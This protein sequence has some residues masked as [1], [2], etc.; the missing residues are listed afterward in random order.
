MDNRKL[1]DAYYCHHRDE[2]LTF[3][4]SR[5]GGDIMAADDMVQELFLHLL[6]LSQPILEA[7]LHGMIYTSLRHLINDHYRRLAHQRHYEQLLTA[8]LATTH[9]SAETGLALREAVEHV[10]RGL[11]HV[12]AGCRE[13]YRMHIYDGMKTAEIAQLTGDGYKSVEYRLGLARKE[14]RQ[15]LRHI[16]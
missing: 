10:E 12:A 8:G 11:Q 15:Y 3:A 14:V 13:V 2:L 16:S 9:A 4:S 1:I 6:A 7:S 5:L